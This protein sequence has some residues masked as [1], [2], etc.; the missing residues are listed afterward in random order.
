MTEIETLII[1][2]F[3]DM[4]RKRFSNWREVVQFIEKDLKP[5]ILPKAKWK[6]NTEQKQQGSLEHLRES[7]LAERNVILGYKKKF[8]EL[9]RLSNEYLKSNLKTI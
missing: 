6:A 2:F 5:L 8:I 3:L 7:Y 4:K 9:I 1:E